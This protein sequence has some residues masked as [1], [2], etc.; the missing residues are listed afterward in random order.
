[1]SVVELLQQNERKDLLR[2]ITAGSV[3]DGKSTLIG[4]LL[5]ESNCIFEDQLDSVQKASG[6]RGSF[7][8]DLDLSLLTDGLKAEREQ[9]IT[10]DVAYR[11]FSTP[12]RKFIVAD[13]P[14]HEQYTRNMATGASTAS[15]MVILVDAS[16]GVLVQ[17]KRHAFIASLLGIQ[18]VVVTV[19]KM[20]LVDYSQEV[21]EQVRQDFSDYAAKLDVRDLTFIPVS[22]LEGENIISHSLKMPWY[23]GATLM[24]YLQTVHIAS[25]ANLIDLRFP[26]QMVQRLDDTTRAYL[27]TVASGVM[28]P[29]QEVLVMP[30][31]TR[32]RIARLI[33]PDG[34]LDEAFSPL[35]CSVV[36]EDQVDVSRGNLIVHSHNLP[37]VGNTVEAMLVWMSEEPMQPGRN[38]VLKHTTRTM[39]ATVSALRYR[40]NVETLHRQ[41][42]DELALNEIGRVVI[43]VSQPLMYDAYAGNRTTGGFILIDRVTNNTV[44][45]GMILE[46][47]PNELLDSG[48]HHVRQPRSDHVHVHTSLVSPADRAKQLGHQAC[49]VWLTGLVGSGKTTTAY[50]LE[51]R[52]FDQGVACCVLNG[53]NLRLGL[54]KELSFSAEDR[55]EQARRAAEIAKTMNEAGLVVICDFT[56]PYAKDR[57][58][59]REIVGADR[60]VE[61]HVDAPLDICRTRAPEDVYEQAD[62]GEIRVFPGVTA[63]YEAPAEPALRLPTGEI[64]VD[65]CV[66]RLVA[67]LVRQGVLAS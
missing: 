63:P 7:H 28:R 58:A 40:M 4:R 25:D 65:E 11:Y 36:L 1:M 23:S 50:S 5:Y 9:G 22:A 51:K 26:V 46:R 32:S 19:N 37:H 20:D 62:R 17:S 34:D 55:Y 60:F 27:G 33:G 52:L 59:V 6:R 45:A 29:G 42:G 66:E 31:G 47:D 10:I 38:Y 61:V 16:Q 24:N 2:F 35:A 18:H 8:D 21:F 64:P 53:A 44:A 13:T 43:D 15:L 57:D 49:T 41:E 67:L 14:G 39:G 56:S 3:D 54:S 30:T 48:E 12:G